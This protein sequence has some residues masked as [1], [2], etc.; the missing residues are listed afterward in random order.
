MSMTA[1]PTVSE[2]NEFVTGMAE[3]LGDGDQV[4]A[5]THEDGGAGVPQ[6]VG[7]GGVVQG[8]GLG[9]TGDDGRRATSGEP[10]AAAVEEQRRAG[11]GAGP[12]G[13]SASPAAEV[14]AELGVDL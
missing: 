10:A 9:D 3:D 7:G 1:M 6:D 8:G 12:H 4:G 2:R 11:V 5:A 14:L 13:R